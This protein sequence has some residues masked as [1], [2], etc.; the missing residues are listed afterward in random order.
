[1]G[2]LGCSLLCFFFA[3]LADF[4]EAKTKKWTA[5]DLAFGEGNKIP[6]IDPKVFAHE[7]SAFLANYFRHVRISLS[8]AD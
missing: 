5:F 8:H 1:L 6:V 7:L 2:E 4:R 3:S